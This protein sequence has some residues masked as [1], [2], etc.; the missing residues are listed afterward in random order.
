MS[1]FVITA[2]WDDV[3]HLSQADKDE[4]WNSFPPHEREARAKGVPM[5]GSGRIFPVDEDMVRTKA[6]PIPEHWPQIVGI[7]FGWDHPF[8]ASHCA[9]DRD[10][11][12]FYV[13][14]TYRQR[15][16]VP[17][18]HAA[19]IKPWGDWLPI[20]WPHDAHQHDK[21]S[22]KSLREQYESHGLNMLPEQASHAE[23][24]NSVEAGISDMLERMMTGRW[25]V[26]D[27]NLDWFEEMRMYH[28]EDGKI[29]KIRDDLLSSSRYALMMKRFAETKP[30]KAQLNYNFGGIA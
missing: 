20:A 29:V 11:D 12:V 6:V 18:I 22:G 24:G 19:A 10:A 16:A 28:R 25:K 3:P 21:G 2:T 17:A 13:V 7:D 8:G 15:E 30:V 14:N 5:L 27:H 4:L 9:W 26:F 1:R 23:G